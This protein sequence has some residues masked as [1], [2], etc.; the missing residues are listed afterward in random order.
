MCVVSA[1]CC[2]L[3]AATAATANGHHL[4]RHDESGEVSGKKAEASDVEAPP[5]A[6]AGRQEA[7]VVKLVAKIVV[8]TDIDHYLTIV[9]GKTKTIIV[10]ATTNTT[11]I[12]RIMTSMV[13]N[14]AN[15]KTTMSRMNVA[16]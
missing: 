15:M 6:R 2:H 8:V 11:V 16:L 3:P 1:A 9:I 5:A 10:S 13:T 14:M 7:A 12:T 4:E